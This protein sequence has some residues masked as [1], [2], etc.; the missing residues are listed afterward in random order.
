MQVAPIPVLN[1]TFS[2]SQ[3]GVTS[4]YKRQMLGVVSLYPRYLVLH[5]VVPARPAAICPNETTGST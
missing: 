5:A 4:R 3:K 2:N 1:L